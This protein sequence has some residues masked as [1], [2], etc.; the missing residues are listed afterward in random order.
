MNAQEIIQ[1]RINELET[2]AKAAKASAR[3]LLKQSKDQ[4]GVAEY[5]EA[6]VNDLKAALDTLNEP[7]KVERKKAVKK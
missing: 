2:E 6:Q 7:I 3:E 4:D 5:A 1:A